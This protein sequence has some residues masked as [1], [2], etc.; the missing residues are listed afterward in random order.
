MSAPLVA[1]TEDAYEPLCQVDMKSL[2]YKVLIWVALASAG[3]ISELQAL[4][5]PPFLIERA[6]SFNLFFFLKTTMNTALS[7]DIELPSFHPDTSA[8]LEQRF[9]QT[10]PIQV[11]KI[12]LERSRAK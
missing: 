9:Q 1:L 11:L 7:G 4:V 10:H 3:H 12:Y 2:T 8:R 5:E 6:Q